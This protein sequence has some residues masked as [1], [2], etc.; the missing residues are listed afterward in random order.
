MDEQ[1]RLL[2]DEAILK[3]Y[4]EA[5][6][7]CERMSHPHLGIFEKMM[8][9]LRAIAEAQDARSYAFGYDA[10]VKAGLEIGRRAEQAKGES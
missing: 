8:V 2:S 5:V 7:A 3:A 10:G 6:H 4:D 1:E 9:G